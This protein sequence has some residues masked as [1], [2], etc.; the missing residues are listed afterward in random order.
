M[1]ANLS[2][3]LA[4][5]EASPERAAI[6]YDVSSRILPEDE[7]QAELAGFASAEDEDCHDLITEAE[8]I[9]TYCAAEDSCE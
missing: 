5:L 4:R 7:W 6:R 3:R 1:R 2:A 9:A 8:W